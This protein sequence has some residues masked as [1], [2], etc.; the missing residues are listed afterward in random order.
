MSMSERVQVSAFLEPDSQML[1]VSSIIPDKNEEAPPMDLIC[2]IDISYSMGGSAACQTDGK[3]EYEDLGFSLMDLVK[4]AVKTV[5]KVMRPS[6]RV[7]IVLFDDVI[8]V[9]FPF[10]E[11]TDANRDSVL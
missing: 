2:I 3:T 4:H 8:E 9:P 10:A 5:V 11:M 7:C 6:D 1:R